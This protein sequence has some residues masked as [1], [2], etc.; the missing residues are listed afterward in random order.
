MRGQYIANTD[1][2]PLACVADLASAS[3][4]PKPEEVIDER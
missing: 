3:L 2:K 4:P 1:H